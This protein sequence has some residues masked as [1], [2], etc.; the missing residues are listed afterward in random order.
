MALEVSPAVPSDMPRLMDVQF[1]AFGDKDP[2][3]VAVYSKDSP[4]TR[5]SAASRTLKEAADDLT[6]QILKCSDPTTG[7]IWGFAKWNV[8]DRERPESEWQ[9]REAV[10]WCEGRE[11]EVAEAFLGA[12]GDMRRK[13]WGGRP[14]VCEYKYLSSLAHC[15][16]DSFIFWLFRLLCV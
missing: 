10:D 7:T 14:H 11:K 6:L 8:Y 13:I 1:S 9:K 16:C 15:S 5:A 12:T 3:H 2:Y 4:S